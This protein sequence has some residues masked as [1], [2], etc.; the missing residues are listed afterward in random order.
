MEDYFKTEDQA[1]NFI[2]L[3]TE[4]FSK[5]PPLIYE[6][7]STDDIFGQNHFSFYDFK[8]DTKHHF[9]ILKRQNNFEVTSTKQ[10]MSRLVHACEIGDLEL[11]NESIYTTNTERGI[12]L[13]FKLAI[14]NDHLNI[15]ELFVSKNFIANV[16][17]FESPL[18]TSTVKDSINSFLYLLSKYEIYTSILA[19]ILR[20]NS[21]KILVYIFNNKQLSDTILSKKHQESDWVQRL[22]TQPIFDNETIEIYRNYLKSR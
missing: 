11:F 6:V 4:G 22:L 9:S 15:V 5:I 13:G 3:K 21:K 18:R 12:A 7:L 17:F 10:K 14:Y 16:H 19:D 2:E 8:T 20:H 1:R